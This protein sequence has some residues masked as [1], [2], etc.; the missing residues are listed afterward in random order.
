MLSHV[1][2]GFQE[3]EREYYDNKDRYGYDGDRGDRGDENEDRER[4]E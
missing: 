4:F 2:G 3:D 1:L